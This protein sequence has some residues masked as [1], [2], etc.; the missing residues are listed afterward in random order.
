M[1][2]FLT[3]T[4]LE[5][6]PNAYDGGLALCGPLAAASWFMT[7]R[8]FDISVVFD[9]TSKARCPIRSRSSPASR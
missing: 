6:F 1:G 7:R 9:T 4:L 2:G 8:P 5:M 3:T